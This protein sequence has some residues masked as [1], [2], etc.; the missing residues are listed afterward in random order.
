LKQIL[1]DYVLK[2]DCDHKTA[3]TLRLITQYTDW[4]QQGMWKL[5]EGYDKW[6][7][8]GVCLEKQWDNTQNREL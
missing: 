3:V 8:V 7:I 1:G 4:Y 5:V 6:I 2:G